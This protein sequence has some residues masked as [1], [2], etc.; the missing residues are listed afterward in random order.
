MRAL[1]G[2]S[3]VGDDIYS[4]DDQGPERFESNVLYHFPFIGGSS[5]V[6]FVSLQKIQ[7]IMKPSWVVILRLYVERAMVSSSCMTRLNCGIWHSVDNSRLF[8]V[9]NEVGDGHGIICCYIKS[10]TERSVNR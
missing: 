10:K 4:D 7:I 1:K 3:P 8:P 5:S 2:P 6:N 9:L